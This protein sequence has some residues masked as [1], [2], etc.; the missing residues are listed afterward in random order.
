[1]DKLSVLLIR[2]QKLMGRH[3]GCQ[4]ALLG[5][6]MSSLRQLLQRMGVL[7]LQQAS[8]C[9]HEVTLSMLVCNGDDKPEFPNN[10]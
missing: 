3:A 2:R 7:M 10:L 5:N 9:M 8:K 6:A 4:K 1:M